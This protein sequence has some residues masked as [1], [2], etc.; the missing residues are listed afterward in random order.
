LYVRLVN[1]IINGN[2]FNEN[3]RVETSVFVNMGGIV[4]IRQSVI[5]ETV[6]ARRVPWRKKM[7]E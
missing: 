4:K 7:P 2:F 3:E 5:L 1:R 6:T